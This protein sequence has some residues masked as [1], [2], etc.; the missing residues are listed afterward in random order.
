VLSTLLQLDRSASTWVASQL[1]APWLQWTL[2]VFTDL[3][4]GAVVWYA[5]A[6][7]LWMLAPRLVGG[8]ARSREGEAAARLAAAPLDA[9]RPEVARMRAAVWRAV[10]A[11]SL[12]MLLANILIKPLVGRERPFVHGP[13]ASPLVWQPST[14]SFPSGHAASAAAGA[15]ALA[16][17]WP[18]AAAPL[19]VLAALIALSRVALGVHYV[20]DVLAGILVGLLAAILASPRGITTPQRLDPGGRARTAVP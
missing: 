6:G 9:G 2:L 16:R 14:R 13:A 1:G 20:G 7:L 17:V 18:P 12:A 10:M 8:R 15:L 19:T 11:V 4:I 5:L 3:G